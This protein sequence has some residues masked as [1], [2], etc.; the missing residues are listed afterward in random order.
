MALRVVLAVTVFAIS[1]WTVVAGAV[2]LETLVMPGKVIE[3]HADVESDCENCHVAFSREKQRPL[4]EACHKDIALDVRDRVG[5]HG[6]DRNAYIQECATCHTEHV[7]RDADIVRLD[8]QLFDHQLTDFVLAGAHREAS[9]EDCHDAGAKHREAPPL[10][11]D[12]HADDDEHQ[13]AFD[14]ECE[15]CHVVTEWS[16]VEFDHDAETGFTLIGGHLDAECSSCHVEPGYLNTPTE[17][18]ACHRADDT[19]N[20]LNGTDCAFCHVSRNWTDTLFDHAA[21]TAF[22]LTGAHGD[23]ACA[24]CH[25]ANKFEEALETECVA[26]HADDDE[27]DGLNGSACEGCHS[28]TS[29]SESLF[30]H[31]VDTDFPLLGGHSGIDC[32]ECHTAPVHDVRLETDCYACH[33]E[34]DVHENQLGKACGQCHNET[35]WAENVLFDHGLTDFPL[36]GYHR[37]ADCTGCHETPRFN[38]APEECIDCHSDDDIHQRI[39]GVAGATY[40]TPTAWSLW[41]FDHNRQT[42]F[43]LDGAHLDL[44]C[45]ACHT[46]PITGGIQLSK[47]CSGCHRSDDVHGGNFGNDCQ[48]C[49]TTRNFQSVERVE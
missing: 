7:G 28:S 34:Q 29:W 13:G 26:C 49:H 2:D 38:D 40:H 37:D 1:N 6:R 31:D 14:R 43:G 24:D 46:R 25:I 48:R 11:F 15:S 20:G 23:I 44:Q 9:C 5:Y 41:E 36:I 47:T 3:G 35:A 10:C 17:C 21:G 39:L 22:A 18:Y 16:E 33:R 45:E 30:R 4:C 19:H 12:C 42:D 8:P 27:H 32:A